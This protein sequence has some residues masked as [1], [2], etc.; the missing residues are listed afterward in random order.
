MLIL[1]AIRRCLTQEVREEMRKAD[2]HLVMM[3][4]GMTAQLQV[5]NMVINSLSETIFSCCKMVGS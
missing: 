3:P 1:G 4:A 5:L 2:T